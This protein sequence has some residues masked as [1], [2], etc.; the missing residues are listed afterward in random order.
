MDVFASLSALVDG[1]GVRLVAGL[2]DDWTKP[3]IDWLQTHSRVTYVPV[4]RESEAVAIA[5][6]AFFTG[7]PAMAVMGATGLFNC[8]GEL[9]TLN[10]RHQIPVFLLVSDRGSIRDHQIYQEL[11]GRR[12]KP[13]LESLDIPWIGFSSLE[14]LDDG[15]VDA[16]KW[17]RVQKRPVVAFLDRRILKPPPVVQR[18]ADEGS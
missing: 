6:G 10:I 17:C 9:A 13:V 2:P 8:L 5:S 18:S 3:I 16:Y 14:D 1:P 7:T 11:Q 12:L 15:L 4:A